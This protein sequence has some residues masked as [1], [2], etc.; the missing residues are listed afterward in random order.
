M[1][2]DTVL[3]VFVGIVALIFLTQLGVLFYI[4][5]AL[6]QLAAHLDDLGRNVSRTAETL[7]ARI[8]ELLGSARASA[9][10]LRALEENLTR[11]SDIVYKRVV[12]L[13]KFLSEATDAARLQIIR[14]QDTV[15]L[16]CHRTQ[17]AVDMLYRGVVA[18][19]SETRAI[20][21]GVRVGLAVLLRRLKTT[22][23]RTPHHDGEMFI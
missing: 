14:I 5:R 3:T 6:R 1:E 21:N 4:V 11:T 16:A 10:K 19:V 22:S 7:S 2:R 17:N 13:D 9:D 12:S 23:G 15:D 18:P 8:D 20:L